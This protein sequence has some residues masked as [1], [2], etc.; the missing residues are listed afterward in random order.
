M[1]TSSNTSGLPF[2]V[3]TIGKVTLKSTTSGIVI[4]SETCSLQV[5]GEKNSPTYKLDQAVDIKAEEDL[6]L[7]CTAV[8]SSKV[9]VTTTPSY[10][11][12]Y[13]TSYGDVV[14]TTGGDVSPI[15]FKASEEKPFTVILPKA[16]VP[17]LYVIGLKLSSND[18]KSNTIYLNYL[19]SGFNAT[20]KNVSLNKDYY[21]KGEKAQVSFFYSSTS[22]GSLTGNRISSVSIPPLNSKIQIL[23]DK[24]KSCA[25]IQTQTLIKASDKIEVPISI[26]SNC[27][28]PKIILTLTDDKG[29]IFDQKEFKVKTTSV[30]PEPNTSSNI[31][32]II[33]LLVVLC[34]VAIYTYSSKRK[35]TPTSTS[36]SAESNPVDNNIPLGI[37]FFFLLLGLLSFLPASKA[38]ANSF[39]FPQDAVYNGCDITG[40]INVDSIYDLDY[41]FNPDGQVSITPEVT[42][43]GCDG[44]KVTGIVDY[45]IEP[46]FSGQNQDIQDI[47]DRTYRAYRYGINNDSGADF[48]ND[49]D[50]DHGY[51]TITQSGDYW[52]HFQIAF[53][54][55][56]LMGRPT[57]SLGQPHLVHTGF[58]DNNHSNNSW[59]YYYDET[60]SVWRD[61]STYTQDHELIKASQVLDYD[62]VMHAY[63]S[64]NYATSYKFDSTTSP[65]LNRATLLVSTIKFIDIKVKARPTVTVWVNN[66]RP[67]ATIKY[68]DKA[69]VTWT[70]TGSILCNCTYNGSK[71][72]GSSD[73]SGNGIKNSSN[74]LLDI[75]SSTTVNVHCD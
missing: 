74:T 10:E 21:L 68:G 22:A 75:T 64:D 44:R 55:E 40:V 66:A 48:W 67:S 8:N 59:E 9:A 42:A 60:H 6:K 70:P 13:R 31:K 20:I 38:S 52:M 17:Q 56:A 35:K 61:T 16:N 41:R 29:T 53:V 24:D 39:V 69:K 73:A 37:V 57:P 46:R 34:F 54:G 14:K 18:V 3:K 71:S 11:T 49:A 23:N 27:V 33:I 30:I 28:D 32:Y 36:S 12:R 26:T 45:N 2:G 4:L 58:T 5:V 7:S 19:I 63:V 62:P 65:N 47:R 43:T 72:C 15:S 25:K 51:P 50:V 1:L